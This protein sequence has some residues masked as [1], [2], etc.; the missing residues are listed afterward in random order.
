MIVRLGKMWERM[1]RLCL[2]D[3]G[4]GPFK[5]ASDALSREVAHHYYASIMRRRRRSRNEPHCQNAHVTFDI[6]PALKHAP[7]FKMVI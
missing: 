1:P 6:S 5:A 2:M 3:E 4:K 7:E